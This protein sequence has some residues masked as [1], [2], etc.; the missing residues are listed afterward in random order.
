MDEPF[1]VGSEAETQEKTLR[2]AF[3]TTRNPEDPI[4]G[5]TVGGRYRMQR[6]L[7]HGGFGVIYLAAD[8]KMLSRPVVV[9]ALHDE[10]TGN[11][12]SAR[13]FKQEIEALARIDHPSIVGIFDVG[14]MPDGKPYIVM[15]YVDGFSLRSLITPEGL[16]FWRAANIIRQTGRALS[17][18]HDRGI[19]HRDLKPENIMVQTLGGG[20]EQVKIIDFGIARVKNS[21]VSFTTASD[22]TVGT[23]AYMSPEQLI[24][25]QLTPAS[26]VYCLAVI[27]YELLTGRRPVNPESAYQLLEMQRAGVRIRPTDLRPGLNQQ[28][29]AIILKALSFEAG[30]RPQRARDF[31]DEL[32]SALVSDEPTVVPPAPQSVTEI[33]GVADSSS[34]V[35]VVRPPQSK[36]NLKRLGIIAAATAV[37]GLLTVFAIS[38]LIKPRE[39]ITASPAV[40]VPANERSYRYWLTVQKMRDDKPDGGEITMTGNEVY[41]NGWKFRFNL[42][43]AQPGSLYLLNESPGSA[44]KREVNALFPTPQNG[45]RAQLDRYQRLQTRWYVFD[46]KTG[47]EKLWIIWAVDPVPELDELFR[48]AGQTGGVL[49]EDQVATV[50]TYLKQYESTP[51]VAATDKQQKFTLVKGQGNILVSLQELSHEAY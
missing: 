37:V 11:E 29:E 4:I 10:G 21:V 7:G 38:K 1:K 6:K 16:D 39:A 2:D 30:N 43:P 49:S 18:A 27:A 5:T 23:I 40:I 19:L 26:D 33:V 50:Q 15:Q 42:D 3:A 24:A 31:G 36:W 46:K 32:A 8:E 28:A 13:K 12:W 17:A 44:D 51:P 35:T 14:E 34:E 48:A 25:S 47:V 20:D 9:K 41:G 22:K 45:G